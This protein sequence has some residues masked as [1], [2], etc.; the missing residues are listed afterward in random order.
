MNTAIC[1]RGHET[2][3]DTPVVLTRPWVVDEMDLYT[4]RTQT[5]FSWPPSV[6]DPYAQ[7]C[8][9]LVRKAAGI[10]EGA[11][12]LDLTQWYRM[13]LR[14]YEGDVTFICGASAAPI[15]HVDSCVV[16]PEE[17]ADDTG[18]LDE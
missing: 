12:I 1:K 7:G 18:G 14:A 3:I 8:L 15:R 6:R 5:R 13:D 10:P 16:V 4:L 17:P 11:D 9:D 2:V